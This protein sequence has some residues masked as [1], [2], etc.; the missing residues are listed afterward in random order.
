MHECAHLARA[1]RICGAEGTVLHPVCSCDA[2]VT[3]AAGDAVAGAMRSAASSAAASFAPSLL[4]AQIAE[5]AAGIFDGS[6]APTRVSLG[7]SG[8]LDANAVDARRGAFVVRLPSPGARFGFV[9]VSV[10]HA[11]GGGETGWTAKLSATPPPAE[12]L[13]ADL[14]GVAAQSG[15]LFD[16]V[17]IYDAAASA[18]NMWPENPTAKQKPLLRTSAS[19]AS[20][21][22]TCRGYLRQSAFALQNYNSF[23]LVRADVGT[24]AAAAPRPATLRYEIAVS[25]PLAVTSDASALE[26]ML[27]G[28]NAAIAKHAVLVPLA[29]FRAHAALQI[30]AMYHSVNLLATLQEAA[31]AAG[32]DAGSALLDSSDFSR[33]DGEEARVLFAQLSVRLTS[34]NHE[35]RGRGAQPLLLSFASKLEGAYTLVAP[36]LRG[37]MIAAGMP[38]SLPDDANGGINS[39]ARRGL[40]IMQRGDAST[41]ERAERLLSH[42]SSA[43]ALRA[44]SSAAGSGTLLPATMLASAQASARA[45]ASSDAASAAAV[46][47]AARP[48]IHLASFGKS[49]LPSLMRRSGAVID[50]GDTT[51]SLRAIG[52]GLLAHTAGLPRDGI[53][54]PLHAADAPPPT[55]AARDL[56][57]IGPFDSTGAERRRGVD[58]NRRA[59]LPRADEASGESGDDADY[60]G[61]PG[62]GAESPRNSDLPAAKRRRRLQS[63]AAT[64]QHSVASNDDAAE[65]LAVPP[66]QPSS[67]SDTDDDAGFSRKGRRKRKSRAAAR[68]S[69]PAHSRRIAAASAS[70]NNSGD[71]DAAADSEFEAAV[72][73]MSDDAE[74]APAAAAVALGSITDIASSVPAMA[75]V[76]S[77]VSSGVSCFFEGV[78]YTEDALNSLSLNVLQRFCRMKDG[79]GV[80]V[81]GTKSHLI[82]VLLGRVAGGKKRSSRS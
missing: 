67:S 15:G 45:C 8:N 79:D 22:R 29:S 37:I 76:A 24:A 46:S 25:L 19:P 9:D 44:L 82:A 14:L 12:S 69:R 16:R 66:P 34:G 1:F 59:R 52:Y 17:Q 62:G 13:A 55:A 63:A 81:R 77:A 43:T 26:R 3:A 71:D 60:S 7:L 38:A 53:D 32:S 72:R 18:A 31:P 64:L 57:S 20:F 40:A 56:L 41:L 4:N 23:N 70:H 30:S 80:S 5:L 2:S 75:Q 47:N 36:L 33:E 78:T 48:P 27:A 68:F 35:S 21:A 49:L 6:A 65:E 28:F 10:F 11:L 50:T 74:R 42:L 73:A 51:P 39:V 54:A 61:A 58:R